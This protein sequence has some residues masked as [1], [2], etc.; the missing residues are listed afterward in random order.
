[1]GTPSDVSALCAEFGGLPLSRRRILVVE[2]EPL[3]RLGVV[4]TLE[5][6]GHE[7]VEAGNA[8]EGIQVL[9]QN[10]DI[11]LVLTDIDMPGSMDGL[12]LA[13]YVARRWPPVRLIVFSGKIVPRA[14]ELPPKARFLSKP[15]EEPVLLNVIGE[16]I[17][18]REQRL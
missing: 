8:D 10:P 9:E 17:G 11:A 14:E 12:R 16:M 15:Y 7:A 5:D 1:M 18:G 2:D 3:I 13:H 6:A 4:S